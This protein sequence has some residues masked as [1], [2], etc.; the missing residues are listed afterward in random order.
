MTT[1][2]KEGNGN[3]EVTVYNAHMALVKEK[4]E[5]YLNNGINHIEYTNVTSNI[6]P[7][8]VLLEDPTN[9]KTTV[10]EQ[11]CQY[12]LFSSSNIFDKYLEKKITVMDFAGQTILAN[13]SVMNKI[14]SSLKEMTEALCL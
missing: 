2:I 9:N 8:S 12:D 4:R 1:G 10:L 6:D 11:Q 5:I 14:K 13:F 7:T 3:T